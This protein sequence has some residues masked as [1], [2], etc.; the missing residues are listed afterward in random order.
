MAGASTF[1]A[2]LCMIGFF[3]ATWGGAKLARFIGLPALVFEIGIGIALGPHVGNLIGKEYAVCTS[4]HFTACVPP[5]NI[6]RLVYEGKP[7]G[8]TYGR[9]ANMH[10]CPKTLYLNITNA[11]NA[12]GHHWHHRHPYTTTVRPK[13]KRVLSDDDFSLSA[14]A[15]AVATTT[16]TRRPTWNNHSNHSNLTARPPYSSYVECLRESCMADLKSR[17]DT[18]PD[19]FTLIGHAGV[20]LAIFQSSLRF[21]LEHFKTS[22]G[23]WSLI[24][25][26]T[27][28][29]IPFLTGAAGCGHLSASA[30]CGPC[31]MRR[32]ALKCLAETPF[33]AFGYFC[34][35][36]FPPASH[37]TRRQ[38]WASWPSTAGRWCPMPFWLVPPWCRRA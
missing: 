25:A 33:V 20:G 22:A 15:R 16:T 13:P 29:I 23:L 35:S 14:H 11:T 10:Y 38:E 18:A 19:L 5:S 28:A 1:L 4:R 27:G 37:N 24:V 6:G 2:L 3:A 30:F 9:I 21:D 12:S 31:F 32:S 7:L 8:A 17:C 36:C 26:V 34:W